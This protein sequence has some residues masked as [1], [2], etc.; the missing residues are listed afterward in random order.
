MNKQ[1]KLSADFISNI[2]KLSDDGFSSRKISH[3]MGV[4]KSTV[5]NYIAMRDVTKGVKL[6]YNP[7]DASFSK[8]SKVKAE[9]G[10]KGK[11]PRILVYDLETAPALSYTFGRWKQNISEDGVHQEGGWIICASYRWLDEDDS[12]VIY[13]KSDI[14]N[15]EDTGVVSKLWELYNEADVVIAHNAL[16]FDHKVLQGR[17]LINNL[18]PLPSVKVI[19][20][21]VMAKK[22]FR[23]PSNKLDSL[24]EILGLG[25]KIQTGGIKLW[26][27]VLSGD[28]EALEDMLDYCQHDTD[29]LCDVYLKLRS[30][31]TG[32]NFNASHYYDDNTTRCNV[33]GSSEIEPTGRVTYTDVSAFE[34]IRCTS[35]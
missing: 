20:T 25:R 16:Q 21:L 2:Y 24:A 9:V 30:F 10:V 27:D 4:S 34:E 11:G 5:N 31:G 6:Q 32:S 12:Y 18:P 13:S 33:C 29:L 35:S 14:A 17:V 8:K 26:V 19:D 3:I 7:E 1:T 22:N 23:L 15:K 28:E